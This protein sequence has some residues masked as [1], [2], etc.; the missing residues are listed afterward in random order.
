MC[1][2]SSRM[3]GEGKSVAQVVEYYDNGASVP[4]FLHNWKIKLEG[5]TILTKDG[6]GSSILVDETSKE[7]KIDIVTDD[8]K[9]AE[10]RPVSSSLNS[11]FLLKAMA[12]ASN[13]GL[14][15]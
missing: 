13:E 12:L 7:W 2:N 5:L 9:V 11:H 10:F 3:T 4:G 1:I 14:R 8:V 6:T 15:T